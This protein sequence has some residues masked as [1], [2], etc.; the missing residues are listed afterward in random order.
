MLPGVLLG[1]HDGILGA[2]DE[3][4]MSVPGNLSKEGDDEGTG[5]LSC[6]GMVEGKQRSD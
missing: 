5:C 2:I 1:I 3:V 4:M 6:G